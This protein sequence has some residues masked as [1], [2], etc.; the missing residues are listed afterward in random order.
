MKVF[1]RPEVRNICNIFTDTTMK[2][3][4]THIE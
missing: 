4:Q 2:T 1:K 3:T